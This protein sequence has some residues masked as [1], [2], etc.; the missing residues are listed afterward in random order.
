MSEWN[1]DFLIAL[2]LLNELFWGS[3]GKANSDAWLAA[4]ALALLNTPRV[5]MWEI[6]QREEG[7]I[8]FLCG[9][10][11]KRANDTH[12]WD[13]LI[14]SQ[15]TSSPLASDTLAAARDRTKCKAEAS[16]ATVPRRGLLLSISPAL[17]ELLL[18][19]TQAPEQHL[20]LPGACLLLMDVAR[21]A[22]CSCGGLSCWERSALWPWNLH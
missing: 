12:Q 2:L 22:W 20:S 17:P 18:T 3:R 1:I 21:C 16:Y 6:Q 14:L 4:F 11:I 5:L 15:S 9:T 13:R 19:H 7:G 8:L 10:D